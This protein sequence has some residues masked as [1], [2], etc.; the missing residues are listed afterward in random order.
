MPRA[1]RGR[2]RDVRSSNLSAAATSQVL[3][4]SDTRWISSLFLSRAMRVLSYISV[5]ACGAKLSLDFAIRTPADTAISTEC[6]F[7]VEQGGTIRQSSGIAVCFHDVVGE[8]AGSVWRGPATAGRAYCLVNVDF[9][10][11]VFTRA[12][13]AQQFS[14]SAASR[15]SIWMLAQFVTRRCLRIW[16]QV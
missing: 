3:S 1:P 5:L 7:H 14:R 4:I 9:P 6:E 11:P 16:S 10:S 2:P 15:S 13:L 8:G 12:Q